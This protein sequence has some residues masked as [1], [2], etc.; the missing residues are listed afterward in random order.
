MAESKALHKTKV[1]GSEGVF[2]MYC[3]PCHREGKR[4]IAC[5]FCSVCVT[6]FCL[7]CLKCHGRFFP[8]HKPLAGVNMP[9]DLCIEKCKTHYQE[10]LKYFCTTCN[11]FVCCICKP[12]L[13]KDTC[14]L[15]YLPDYVTDTKV[16]EE[17][18]DIKTYN[19]NIAKRLSDF[20]GNIDV[21]YESIFSCASEAKTVIQSKKEDIFAPFEEEISNLEKTVHTAKTKDML[22][23]DRAKEMLEVLHNETDK[24]S[25][26]IKI[27]QQFPKSRKYTSFLK[28]KQMSGDLTQLNEIVRNLTKD[29]LK[30][31][32]HF[33]DEVKRELND[34]IDRVKEIGKCVATSQECQAKATG[35]AA[36][37][38]EDLNVKDKKD[39]KDCLIFDLCLITDQYLVLS[40]RSNCCLKLVDVKSKKLLY[41]RSVITAPEAV[42]K[43]TE[44]EMAMARLYEKDE[45]RC[46]IQFLKLTN[47]KQ[48][49]FMKRFIL[50]EMFCTNI[51]YIGNDKLV[52]AM[53]ANYHGKVQIVDF[54]GRV[55]HTIDKDENG[56]SLFQCPYYLN[57]NMAEKV[58]Y[59]S[60]WLND[61]FCKVDIDTLSTYQ[62]SPRIWH[63]YG[64]TI[65]ED[66]C[67]YV[68]ESGTDSIHVYYTDDTKN[69]DKQVLLQFSD[70]SPQALLFSASLSK[71]YVS[72]DGSEHL[73]VYNI[74]NS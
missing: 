40:D 64:I 73:K 63:P 29:S 67:I 71:L 11:K 25:E 23:I 62:Y 74:I 31:D 32:N 72:F 35:K 68:C 26:N 45:S 44:S 33:G 28:M 50:T 61:S 27:V 12:E 4:E 21:K 47:A 55:I 48:L 2:E 59:I 41:R 36:Y 24:L 1:N 3:E 57:T 17:L 6:Y 66:C 69:S 15:R 9:Q 14:N 34:L 37:F 58:V 51:T 49:V 60:D 7:I 42:T 10:I 5:A 13:H 18:K 38:V 53:T 30:T 19:S 54:S 52:I 56:E 39:Q 8:G 22:N 70:D 43:I 65:D 16:T 46:I 20:K